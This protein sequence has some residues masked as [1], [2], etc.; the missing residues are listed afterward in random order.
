M[1]NASKMTVLVSRAN[2][3]SAFVEKVGIAFKV[4]RSKNE[5]SSPYAFKSRVVFNQS[6]SEI[7]NRLRQ[8]F[9][10]WTRQVNNDSTNL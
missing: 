4:R 3:S 8:A 10:R 7:E 2:T 9:A 5:N 6:D 1:E